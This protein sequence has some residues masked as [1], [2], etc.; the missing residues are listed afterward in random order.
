MRRFQDF[1]SLCVVLTLLA[2]PALY[3]QSTAE[4]NKA[5]MEKF[6]NEAVN[7]GNLEL[8][9]ELLADNFVEHEAIPGAAQGKQAAKD[10]FVMFRQGFPDMKFTINDMVSSGDKVWTLVTIT[11]T[12]SGP[13]MDMPATGKK[14]SIKGVDIVRF[15]NGQAVEHWGVTDTATMMQQLGMLPEH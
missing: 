10:Y 4:Q 11:G 14:I 12:H 3:G 9:D 15:A 1:I 13:F 2:L 7:Q 5:L 8:V 6:Y